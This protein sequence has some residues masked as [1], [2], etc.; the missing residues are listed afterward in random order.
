MKRV[1]SF[2]LLSS[3]LAVAPARAD[4]SAGSKDISALEALDAVLPRVT[5]KVGQSV[6]LLEVP[7]RDPAVS[8][9]LSAAEK[10][11]LGLGPFRTF[12]DRYFVRPKAP[13]TGVV[14]A[15]DGDT[16]YVATCAWNLLGARTVF[17]IDP[18]TGDRRKATIAGHDENL[19]V[20]LVKV[21]G[22]KW[23][24]L[25][26][27][28]AAKIGAMALLVGR[29]PIRAPFVTFGHVSALGRYRGDAMQVSTR[30]SY[31]NVGGA[32]VDLDGRLLGI[33]SRLSDRTRN[34]QSSGVGFAAPID[35]LTKAIPDLMA[36][37]NIVKR[38]S[39]F[40][41]VQI[42]PQEPQGRTGVRIMKVLPNSAAAKAGLEDGDVIQIF[43]GT[44]LKEFGQLREEL[45]RLQVG[46]KVIISVYR[47]SKDAEK[48]FTVHL[49]AR[50]DGDE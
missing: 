28:P 15:A 44:E 43:H 5:E 9:P 6:I 24:A 8:K 10:A 37:K 40:L 21:E 4:D 19:D 47:P 35:K 2:V 11:A 22:A 13:F 36:G 20:A 32:V 25:E 14:V 16:R 34:G 41:G 1:V 48:D 30:M 33:A 38:K 29:T 7:D 39:P 3:L 23:P 46:E 45:D 49:G 18:A 31:G 27:S 50:P 42:D 26:P 17:A 12:D